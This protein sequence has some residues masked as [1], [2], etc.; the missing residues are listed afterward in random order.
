MITI[1]GTKALCAQTLNCALLKCL[2]WVCKRDSNWLISVE[3]DSEDMSFYLRSSVVNKRSM[4]NSE[5]L[6][7]SKVRRRSTMRSVVSPKR[8]GF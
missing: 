8:G 4:L 5:A 6:C 3:F 7:K 2:S 1:R